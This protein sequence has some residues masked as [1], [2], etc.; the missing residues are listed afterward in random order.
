MKEAAIRKKA[1]DE[2]HKENWITWYPY[3]ARYKK[4]QD[5]FGVFDIIAIH[6]DGIVLFLQITSYSNV[7]ARKKKIQNFLDENQLDLVKFYPRYG[8]G[9][10]YVEVWGWNAKK[11]AFRKDVIH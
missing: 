6:P 5:I 4:E 8:E 3:K 9:E 10:I 2:L 1:L 11:R 7:S